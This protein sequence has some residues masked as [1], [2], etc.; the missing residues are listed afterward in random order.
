MVPVVFSRG[1]AFGVCDLVLLYYYL[2]GGPSSGWGR[3]GSAEFTFVECHST[4]LIPLVHMTMTMTIQTIPKSR[5]LWL[6]LAVC[7]STIYTVLSQIRLARKLA[8]FPEFL[9]RQV[10]VR[11]SD[12]IRVEDELRLPNADSLFNNLTNNLARGLNIW[13][14]L[15]GCEVASKVYHFSCPIAIPLDRKLDNTL[16]GLQPYDTVYMDKRRVETFVEK[17]LGKLTVPIVLMTGLYELRKNEMPHYIPD[18]VVEALLNHPQIVKWFVH[19]PTF[20]VPHAIN[21]TNAFKNKVVAL[22]YGI[23]PT[24]YDP[25]PKRPKP[26]DY[27]REAMAVHLDLPQKTVGV[28]AG[29]LANWTNPERNTIPRGEKL[30][31]PEYYDRLAQS[32][33]V[34]SRSGDRPESQ[35]PPAPFDS[36]LRF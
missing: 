36:D 12:A 15:S 18:Q 34:F 7:F 31:L 2:I 33:F 28:Y 16:S 3:L 4:R 8:S 35:A 25:Y 24:N 5:R 20:T 23:Q 32:K 22:P 21:T 29:Y 14:P 26:V 6:L 9:P 19:N 17:S 30:P 10:D 27:Y 11:P 1:K 13:T